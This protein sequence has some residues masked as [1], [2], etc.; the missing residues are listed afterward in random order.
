MPGSAPT[1]RR[2]SSSWDLCEPAKK[3]MGTRDVQGS[4]FGLFLPRRLV[5]PDHMSGVQ[6]LARLMSSGGRGSKEEEW[7]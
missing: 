6:G 3:R 4:F 7:D 1:F 5:S 2:L